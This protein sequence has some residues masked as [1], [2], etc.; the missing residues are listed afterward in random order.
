MSAG[1]TGRDAALFATDP[2]PAAAEVDAPCICG[3]PRSVH[4]HSWLYRPCTAEHCDC[5]QFH[6]KGKRR[7]GA[8]AI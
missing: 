3:H 5:P 6:P 7:S 2:P 4:D 8:G 1:R